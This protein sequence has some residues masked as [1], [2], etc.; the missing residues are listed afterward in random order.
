MRTDVFGGQGGIP[1]QWNPS[2]DA[3][4]YV[5]TVSFGNKLNSIIFEMYPPPVVKSSPYGPSFG[6]S[7]NSWVVPNNQTIKL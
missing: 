1:F 6:G 3:D 7:W 4:L 2:E 5:V